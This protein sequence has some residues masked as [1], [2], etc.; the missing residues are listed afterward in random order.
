MQEGR[1][2]ETTKPLGGAMP[3]EATR[4]HESRSLET[5]FQETEVQAGDPLPIGGAHRFEDGVYFVLFSR[6]AMR[7]RLE[8]FQSPDD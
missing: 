8:L 4:E 1:I 6:N 7:V 5:S 2:E 3:E